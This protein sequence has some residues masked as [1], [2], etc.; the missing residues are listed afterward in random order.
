MSNLLM[1]K[2]RQSTFARGDGCPQRAPP[3]NF[4]PPEPKGFV[5]GFLVTVG[6]AADGYRFRSV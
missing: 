6:K 3:D 4:E 5:S 1:K 2:V